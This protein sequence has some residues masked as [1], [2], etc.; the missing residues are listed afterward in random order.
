MTMAA[1]TSFGCNDYN[2]EQE[3]TV[4]LH[5]LAKATADANI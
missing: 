1:A 5:V 3:F 4:L 2:E